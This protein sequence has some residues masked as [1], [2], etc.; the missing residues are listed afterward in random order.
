VALA[1]SAPTPAK[2]LRYAS[3]FEPGTMDPHAVATLYSTRVLNQVYDMLVGRDENFA[4]APA[5][6]LSWSLASPTVWRFKLRP[7][8][9]FHDGSPFG[10]DDAVFSIERALAPTSRVRTNL[11]NVTGA[12]KVDELTFEI[13]TSA[14]TPV[15][16]AALTNLRIMSKAWAVKHHVEV[17]QNFQA[18]E[19]TYAARN[20]N[21]TG[22]Y[23]LKEWVPDVKTVLVVN[24]AYWGKRGNVTEAR[25]LVVTS[26]ATRLAGL[27]SGELD[28]VVDPAVQDVERLQ[29]T[30]GTK[31]VTGTSRSTQFLGFDQRRDRLLHG[32]AGGRNPFKD[33]RVRQAVG[34]AI[35]A[36]AI[37]SKVMRNLGVA[38]SALYTSSV[39]GYDPKFDRPP[40][41]DP[42]RARALLKE[43]GY[44]AG[45]S[46]TLHCSSAQPADAVCQAIAG[47][48]ARVGIKVAY[49]PVPFNN[50]IPM[51]TTREVSFY[52][53]G[54]TP[55]TDAEGVLVPL[56]HS[57]NSAGDGEYNA[58]NYS[59]P[60][61]DQLID[62]AR[63]ELDSARR[64]K[65]LAEAMTLVGEDVG[66]IPLI[67]RRISWAMRSTVDAK[68][69]PNDVLDLR[70]VN[71]D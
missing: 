31:I 22:P 34:L 11:P 46:V 6:A 12:R 13:V 52:S 2:T 48:L 43:A 4:L 67:Y 53:L 26:A 36:K 20:A 21:G 40:K 35:D 49:Q 14:P 47:M 23:M 69:R 16:P 70:F 33:L 65:L 24:P 55:S 68:A 10:A 38:G 8:V 41:H 37:E 28:F 71:M 27:V 61:V 63:V 30:P 56:V 1:M 58:G 66:Y 3:A 57:P 15:L 42:E 44:P 32:D 51:V 18:K 7:A 29:K 19:E 39:E 9:K 5:L 17:P 62:Q 50:L 64:L 45:F 25:Y 60:R 59:N 54:W